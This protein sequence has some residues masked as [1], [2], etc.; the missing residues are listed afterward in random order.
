MKGPGEVGDVA[1]ERDLLVWLAPR[2]GGQ[3][4]ERH[5]DGLALMLKTAISHDWQSSNSSPAMG[6]DTN[7]DLPV[8]LRIKR[9]MQ[10]ADE[11]ATRGVRFIIN[12]AAHLQARNHRIEL[13]RVLKQGLRE[14]S[15][16]VAYQ[17]KIDLASG[18]IVAPRR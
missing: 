16:G 17:P 13:I 6:I 8:A 10:A 14:R 9:A 3:E 2:M 12:D 18:R 7:H 1:F 15:I 11:A 4:L 5:A